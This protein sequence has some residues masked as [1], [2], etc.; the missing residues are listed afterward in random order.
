MQTNKTSKP[1]HIHFL[2]SDLFRPLVV[3][4]SIGVHFLV[5]ENLTSLCN[6]KVETS[7][8]T[9]I[10]RMQKKENVIVSLKNCLNKSTYI[11]FRQFGFVSCLQLHF[12]CRGYLRS[13]SMSDCIF[14]KKTQHPTTSSW[15]EPLRSA[16]KKIFFTWP[17]K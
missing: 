4:R 6:S 9:P 1:A 2:V 14:Y 12:W 7:T 8:E 17:Q 16:L 15:N 13:L 11:W 3:S 10:Y 5:T